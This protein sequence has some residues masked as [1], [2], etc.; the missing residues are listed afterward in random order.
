MSEREQA[1]KEF[2]TGLRK[3][4]TEDERVLSA[5]AKVPRERFVDSEHED[6]ALS[7]YAL[8]IAC[9]QTISQ[10]SLVAAMTAALK[11]SPKHKV[12]EIGTGSGYQAAILSHLAKHVFSIERFPL[13]AEIAKERLKKLGIENV[14][15]SEGDGAEGLPGEAPFDRIMV[16]AAAPHMPPALTEQLA[17]GGILIL[18]LGPPGDIQTLIRVTK[19]GAGA[20]KSEDLMSVR[21][22][23]LLPGRNPVP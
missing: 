17:A 11:I 3:R 1:R 6:V 18:P 12:L 15:I 13:L 8:P 2:M 7:D 19:S 22:V 14:S 4:G 16:T 21:F 23:P 10:P 9:G 5:M 20:L